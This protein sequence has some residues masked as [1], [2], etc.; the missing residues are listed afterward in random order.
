M[1]PFRVLADWDIPPEERDMLA[2]WPADI[3]IIEGGTKLTAA[4]KLALA[5]TIDVQAGR[6]R[7]VTAAFLRA[8]ERLRLVHMTGHG[9]DG[10]VR[11]SIPD[12][13]GSRGIKLATADAAAIPIAEFAIMAMIALSR[14]V[15]RIQQSL[16]Q[17]G[18]W[19]TWRGPELHGATACVVGLG[20]I[21]QLVAQRAAAFGMRVG[22]VTQRPD[23]HRAQAE[24]LSFL[25][26]FEDIGKALSVA[27]YTVLAVPLTARTVNLLGPAEFAAFRP[28]SFL[29]NVG[30]G[31]LIDEAAFIAALRDGILGGAAIDCWWCEE[32]D[33]R[34]SGYPLSTAIHQYNVLM[35]PHYCGSTAATRRRVLELI[36][37]NIARL[38]AGEPLINEVAPDEL[39]HMAV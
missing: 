24:D 15:L 17:R 4:A 26:P 21:G 7:T 22:A 25:L 30:R 6:M 12:L 9:V 19:E 1:Q 31:P 18:E 10:L 13:L 5:P 28:G 33:G 23:R 35:T 8:A 38:R 32:E 37:T 36:G 34:R 27:D 11:D 14:R 16:V 3:E 39:R 29:I 2:A 20:P